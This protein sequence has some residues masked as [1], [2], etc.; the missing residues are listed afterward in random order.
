MQ[1][2]PVL[3][4][5]QAD[6][7]R[8]RASAAN[9]GGGEDAPPAK[10]RDRG[11]EDAAPRAGMSREEAAA[12]ASEGDAPAAPLRRRGRPARVI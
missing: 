4:T 12:A 8:V 1:T 2:D 6:V 9:G 10:Q 7:L 3:L 5:T 11:R